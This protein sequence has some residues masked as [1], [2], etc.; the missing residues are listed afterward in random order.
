MF[1]FIKPEP[2]MMKN[3]DVNK[4]INANGKLKQICPIII[5]TAPNKVAP[6]VPVILSAIHPPGIDVI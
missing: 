6:L 3:I 1:G 4:P 2:I 5:N